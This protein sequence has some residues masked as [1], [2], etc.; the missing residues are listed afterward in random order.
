[1]GTRQGHSLIIPYKQLPAGIISP[2]PSYTE[3]AIIYNPNS[4]GNAEE[5]AKQL[6]ADLRSSLPGLAVRL[7]PTER[8][9]HAIEL[10]YGFAKKHK[11][12]LIVAASGDGGYN[13]VING[14]LRAQG[15]GASPVCA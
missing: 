8:A 1:M 12:P 7:L 2:M 4:T 11:N 5:N 3:V 15:E 10:A 14:A 6:Q 13:E 9:G